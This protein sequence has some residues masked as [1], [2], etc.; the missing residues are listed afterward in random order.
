MDYKANP[1]L[2]QNHNFDESIAQIDFEA[3][4]AGENLLIK[5]YTM[6]EQQYNE[7][8]AYIHRV[9]RMLARWLDDYWK[10]FGYKLS[11][12]SKIVIDE[13]NQNRI[14]SFYLRKEN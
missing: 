14:V 7:Q 1:I 4:I 8:R 5:Q 2:L 13:S 11:F 12:W 6:N 10:I 9:W 3:L